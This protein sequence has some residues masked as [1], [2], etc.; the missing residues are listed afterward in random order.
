MKISVGLP[1]YNAESYLAES[2]QSV[3]NQSFKD[4]ELILI[5]DGSTDKS[6]EIANKFSLND[7]RIRVI[8]DGTN[9]KLPYRLNQIIQEAKYP[10]IARMD[11]DDLIHPDRLRIQYD[12]LEKNSEYDLVSSSMI[13]IN[14][15]NQIKGFRG[16]FSLYTDFK[17][18]KRNYPIVHASI[19]VRKEWYLRNQYNLNMSRSQDFELWC[20]TITNN[21]LNMAVIPDILYY[22]REEGMVTSDKMLRSYIDGLEVYK[23]YCKTPSLK[24]ILSTKLKVFSVKI[25]DSFGLLQQITKLRNKKII[26]KDLI[27][28]HSKIIK[29]IVSK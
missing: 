1:F 14:K 7:H 28:Y 6:L 13:S 20:R 19:L 5:D 23:K 22:Y 9:K 10:Y 16:V 27:E 24:V 25:L 4:W 12:F 8:S 3:I 2:I 26:N 21:D 15:K 11:A 29:A 17:E 18:I